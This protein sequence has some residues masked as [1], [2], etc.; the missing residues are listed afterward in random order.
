MLGSLPFLRRCSYLLARIAGERQEYDHPE[1]GLFP[2]GKRVGCRTPPAA[3][4]RARV[5]PRRYGVND[6]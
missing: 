1:A 4:R 3:K 6:Y 5:V 2:S